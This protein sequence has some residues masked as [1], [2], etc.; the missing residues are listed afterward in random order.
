MRKLIIPMLGLALV[1]AA[2]LGCYI[3]GEDGEGEQ[4]EISAECT[5]YVGVECEA[6]CETTDFHFSCDGECN[7]EIDLPSCQAECQAECEALECEVDPGSFECEGYCQAECG[8][9]CAGQCETAEDS[10]ACEGHCEAFCES[11]CDIDCDY[12]PTEVSCEGGC[13]ASCSGGCEGGNIDIDC[14]IDC[15]FNSPI[16]CEGYCDSDGFLECDGQFIEKKDLEAAIQWVKDNMPEAQITF[17]GDAECQGNKCYAE[18]S[19]EASC[20]S[21][22]RR[23]LG[24]GSALALLLAASLV[25]AFRRR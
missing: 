9:N 2:P 5:W 22:P 4:V 21:A 25:L 8:A 14:Y 13:E 19:C 24:L 1:A 17:E 20:I 23:G 6:A 12:D 11:E 15:D 7:G 18:G 16:E 3:E 10:V